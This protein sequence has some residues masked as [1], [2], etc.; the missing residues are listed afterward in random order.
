[1]T[2]RK[3]FITCIVASAALISIQT[4]SQEL[5]REITT[6]REKV[7]DCDTL[8][9]YGIDLSHVRVTDEDKIAR[10]LN[11]SIV[12]PSAWI[13][14]VEEELPPYKYVQAKLGK[15]AFY[16]VQ[17]EVQHNTLQVNPNFIIAEDYS[18]SVDTAYQA[19]KTY[20]LTQK[21]G[22]GLVLI[23]ENFNKH[24]D[25]SSIW[26]TFF[27]LKTREVLWAVRLTGNCKHMGYT[28]HWGSGI[29]K[30][31]KRFISNWY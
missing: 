9:Y 20:N 25:A 31:F 6:Q 29:V 26:I 18:F 23:A 21:S 5:Q 12:Y 11:Y 14:Y 8:Y 17:K 22:I 2:Y 19:V 7:R 28:A 13:A 15:G 24:H 27:D 4:F 3:L 1:M 10:S 16:Y 30:G